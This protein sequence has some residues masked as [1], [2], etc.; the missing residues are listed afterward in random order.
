[1]TPFATVVAVVVVGVVT[2]LIPTG[3]KDDVTGFLDIGIPNRTRQRRGLRCHRCSRRSRCS[4][5]PWDGGMIQG[6][7]L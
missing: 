2:T 3:R 5:R 6:M 7:R 4:R 1:V